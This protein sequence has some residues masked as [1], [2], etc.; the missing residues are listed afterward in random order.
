MLL[1]WGESF[2]SLDETTAQ[3]HSALAFTLAIVLYVLFIMLFSF[4]LYLL[5]GTVLALL[6]GVALS[7]VPNPRSGQ[8]M[9]PAPE[10]GRGILRV[11]FASL[12]I[13]LL[14]EAVPAL[15]EPGDQGFNVMHSAS[16][17]SLLG[18][19]FII[20]F[21]IFITVFVSKKSDMGFIYRF[22][23]LF[24]IAGIL[25]SLI[26]RDLG[27]TSPIILSAGYGC[28][29]LIFWIALSNLSYRYHYSPTRVFGLGR[30]GWALGVLLGGLCARIPLL[31]PN[32]T[33]MG[34]A[35]I[36]LVTAFVL[37][38]LIS[39]TLILPERTIVAITTGYRGKRSTLQSRYHKLAGHH[40]LT[41][42][43][44]EVLAY[45]VK[46]RDSLY[47]QNALNISAGTVSTH[48]QRI[49]QKTGVHSRQELLDLME[50]P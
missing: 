18:S 20:A 40:G 37:L 16:I 47:I 26:P 8:D 25:L 30:A 46:G 22:V 31:I 21:I 35:H 3:I 29:E 5:M 6:S 33:F 15:S 24:L 11:A 49:Y 38:A 41:Q 14:F 17:L 27:T 7:R 12:I 10:E 44:T 23:P 42:R 9:N 4:I 34:T 50:T 43:E 2:G 1:L 13:S 36:L 39:F 19:A 32:F 28:F 45:L 48:R